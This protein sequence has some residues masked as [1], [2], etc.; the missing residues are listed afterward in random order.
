MKRVVITGIGVVSCLG[1][2]Q[3]EVYEALINTKSGI[4]FCE[5]CRAR[6]YRYLYDCM[7]GWRV[8]CRAVHA[9]THYEGCKYWSCVR[10]TTMQ[11]HT[12]IIATREGRN[13]VCFTND[14]VR[15]RRLELLGNVY[16][17]N[18]GQGQATAG[19]SLLPENITDVTDNE[20]DEE[21]RKWRAVPY[22]QKSP[23]RQFE[24]RS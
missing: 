5:E 6:G 2:N 24:G 8:A 9:Q 13:Y 14:T 22:A 21:P 11:P 1:N 12:T 18:E 10:T 3:K 15:R 4:T 20:D 19:E 7:C 17:G 23:I 16:P